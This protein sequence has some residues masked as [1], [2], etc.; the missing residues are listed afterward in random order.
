MPNLFFS[1]FSL[2]FP[3]LFFSVFFFILVTII[4]ETSKV[5]RVRKYVSSKIDDFM[6]LNTDSVKPKPKKEDKHSRNEFFKMQK[7]YSDKKV[8]S[9]AA[10]KE[11]IKDNTLSEAEKNV[12]Y[13]K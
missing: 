10:D 1:F 8:D 2:I 5:N 3:I 4:K 7:D 9:F 6:T 12:L 11:I 13:G